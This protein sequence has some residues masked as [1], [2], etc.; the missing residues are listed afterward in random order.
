MKIL[1]NDQACPPFAKFMRPNAE[2]FPSHVIGER[3]MQIGIVEAKKRLHELFD[4]AINGDEVIITR[5]G[6][7]VAQ[8]VKM[9]PEEAAQ[10]LADE[11][12]AR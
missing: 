8:L 6:K 10:A 1:R 5:W 7:P 2:E 9:M 11:G 12:A 4:A 3:R